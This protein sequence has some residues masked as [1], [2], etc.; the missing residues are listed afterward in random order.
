LPKAPKTIGSRLAA[1]RD[2]RGWTQ[3]QLADEA[4]IS[5]TF[6]SEVENDHRAIGSEG[7]LR[8]ANALGISIDYLLKGETE[9]VPVRHP[10]VVPPELTEAAEDRGWSLGV[11]KDLLKARQIVVARRNRS[12]ASDEP[13][14]SLSKDD[15]VQLYEHLF[16]NEDAR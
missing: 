6:L 8:V 11:A 13:G 4:E 10:L 7:L 9:P 5:V 1:C 3:K 2:E 16:R 14:R 15:W 12:A